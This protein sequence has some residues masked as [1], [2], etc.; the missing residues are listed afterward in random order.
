MTSGIACFFKFGIVRFLRLPRD[1]LP[2][3][4]NTQ[5]VVPNLKEDIN[6]ITCLRSLK[7]NL[8]DESSDGKLQIH[9]KI[10]IPSLRH[11]TI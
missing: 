9:N 1:N 6:H 5:S 3:M 11:L 7:T 10:D 2:F 8:V 4:F